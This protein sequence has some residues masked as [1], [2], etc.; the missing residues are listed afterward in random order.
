MPN[1]V[2]LSLSLWAGI[3]QVLF[4]FR[5]GAAVILMPAF[6]PV[7]FAALVAEF[8]VRSVV[9]PP[10][11]M[12]MLADDERVGSLAPLRYVRSITA[13][14]STLQ[15]RR[16]VD[17]FGVAVLNCY[18]QTELGGEIVGWTAAD[19]REFG[20]TKL[21]AV[22][23]PHPGIEVRADPDLDGELVVR[24]PALRDGAR[25][26][27]GGRTTASGWYRTGDLGRVDDDG[28]V[29]IDGRVSQMINRGGLKVFPAEVE[30][31]LRLAP[32][33]ADVAVVG[34]PDAR[35]GQ[36]P[37]AFVVLTP[38]AALELPALDELARTHLAPY[39]VPVAVR[40]VD[41]LPRNDVGK[42]LARDLVAAANE[43]EER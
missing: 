25:R 9:L 6:E 17:R 10:A 30:E 21:G 32:G 33:V 14:L 7:A 31:V 2:P 27:G 41:R 5:N 37:W 4:A 38:G 23:R 22:G 19:W 3:Y 26:A 43:E 29:W 36:V 40:V 39:K 18:G 11:A 1:L 28:F 24:T 20:A 35:L 34:V 8:G 13:P 15:A 16:F 12:T 42:V